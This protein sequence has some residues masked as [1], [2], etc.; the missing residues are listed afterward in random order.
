MRYRALTAIMLL[1]IGAASAAH[2]TD[3]YVV[4]FTANGK[5]TECSRALW[6]DDILLYNRS[7][8]PATVR[9][10]NQSNG[11][12]PPGA[13]TTL[14]LPARQVTSVE[15]ARRD[16]TGWHSADGSPLWVVHLDVPAN[17]TV[18]S[19]DEVYVETLCGTIPEQPN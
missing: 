15:G 13:A 10:L 16:L 3:V 11:G 5:S 4:R 8:I 18:E 14:T 6:A 17:V 1:T 7:D 12:I 9:L 19:R 2:A